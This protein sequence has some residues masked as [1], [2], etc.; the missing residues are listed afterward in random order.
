[1]L[2]PN[3]KD[4]PELM[5]YDCVYQLKNLVKSYYI[6]KGRL[7]ETL[8]KKLDAIIIDRPVC[9]EKKKEY[10][11]EQSPPSLLKVMNQ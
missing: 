5:N 3:S 8:F 1:M 7:T 2:N 6:K 4:K 9:L 11:L 10:F